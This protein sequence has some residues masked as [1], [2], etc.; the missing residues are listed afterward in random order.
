MRE[1]ERSDVTNPE[2]A[3][4]KITVVPPTTDFRSKPLTPQENISLLEAALTD[5]VKQEVKPILDNLKQLNEKVDSLLK[6][7]RQTG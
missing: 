1:L 2:D 7:D 4:P 3:N 5:V 6:N